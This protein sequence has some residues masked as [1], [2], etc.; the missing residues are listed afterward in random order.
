LRAQLGRASYLD[1]LLERVRA[2]LD[3]GTLRA[4]PSSV[5]KAHS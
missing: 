5:H 2:L 1:N 3:G 4:S